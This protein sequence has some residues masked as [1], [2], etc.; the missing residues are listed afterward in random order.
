MLQIHTLILGDY[1]TNV[2]IVH[3]SHS[4]NCVIIDPGYQPQVILDKVTA[5]GLTVEAILLTHGHFD[6][7]GGVKAIAKETGCRVYLHEDDLKLPPYL[8][9]GELYYTDPYEDGDTVEVAGLTFRVMHTPG[10]TMG[11]VCLIVEDTIFSGDTLFRH[12]CG[13]TDLGGDWA[14]LMRSLQQFKLLESNYPIYPGH[15]EMT[16]LMDE[17]NYNPYLR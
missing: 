10:H 14:T 6:H 4:R 15:G 16:A 3:D 12:G 17:L 9:A 1:E 5:L 2:Y 13:R 8:T 7:V 11:S